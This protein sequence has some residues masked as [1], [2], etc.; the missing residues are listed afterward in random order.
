MWYSKKTVFMPEKEHILSQ[1]T[2]DG[3]NGVK[4]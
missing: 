3:D 2:V 1:S 4:R